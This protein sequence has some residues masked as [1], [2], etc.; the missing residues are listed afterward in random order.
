MAMRR[1]AVPL[2]PVG[3]R[4]AEGQP[5]LS[6]TPESYILTLRSNAGTAAARC[7]G[8]STLLGP[9]PAMTSQEHQGGQC[10]TGPLPR[11]LIAPWQSSL[12]L[13]EWKGEE[14]DHTQCL[15]RV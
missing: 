11:G 1:G 7:W 3:Q 5:R 4:V 14:T 8:P 9:C 6:N 10:G 12:Q 15:P 13:R 2:T